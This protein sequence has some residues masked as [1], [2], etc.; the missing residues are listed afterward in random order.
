[1]AHVT[2]ELIVVVG[3]L[4]AADDLNQR[5]AGAPQLESQPTHV[6]FTAVRG[7][8]VAAFDIAQTPLSLGVAVQLLARA[9]AVGAAAGAEVVDDRA[10]AVTGQASGGTAGFFPL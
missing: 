4:A 10:L 3:V 2:R 7:P 6:R 8:D 1:M 9:A 5:L